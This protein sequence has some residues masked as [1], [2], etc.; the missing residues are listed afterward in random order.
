MA[1][2]DEPRPEGQPTQGRGDE[3]SR[4]GLEHAF[5]SSEPGPSA[6]AAF[7]TAGVFLL[8][9]LVIGLIVWGAAQFDIPMFPVVLLVVGGLFAAFALLARSVKD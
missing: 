5:R 8:I 2:A 7:A 4:P 3:K 6:K 9:A 1:R